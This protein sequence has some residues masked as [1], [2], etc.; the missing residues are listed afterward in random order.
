VQK[1]LDD[2][3]LPAK[4]DVEQR[5]KQ[6]LELVVTFNDHATAALNRILQDKKRY[7]KRKTHFFLFFF[8]PTISFAPHSFQE[9]FIECLQRRNELVRD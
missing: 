7:T 4:G 1:V 6:L 9:E 8:F 2:V 5:T 3:L